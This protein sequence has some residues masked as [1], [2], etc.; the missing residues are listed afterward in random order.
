MNKFAF[1]IYGR[2]VFAEP[3]AG[4]PVK[5]L[6]IDPQSVPSLGADQHHLLLS[7]G[8]SNVR[9][10]STQRAQF[11][12][13]PALDV[14]PQYLE[15]V[16]WQLDGFDLTLPSTQQGL[17]WSSEKAILP[18]LTELTEQA[19]RF[20][21]SCLRAK[22]IVEIPTGMVMP[23]R[24]GMPWPF[25][26][27]PVRAPLGQGMLEKPTL[28]DMIEVILEVPDDLHIAVIPRAGNSKPAKE[29]IVKPAKVGP[30]IISLSHMCAAGSHLGYDKEFAALYEAL[31]NPPAVDER[32]VPRPALG[33]SETPCLSPAFIRF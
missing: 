33:F 9:G 29:V 6:A 28:P 10:A 2:F 26:F 22:S 15:Q 4:G 11:G 18:N 3:A 20:D 13:M 21:A 23:R 25:D 30:T 5:A 31:E 14:P 7:V 19:A 24:M 16:V 8:R 17:H 27:V 12:I 1:R 32:L